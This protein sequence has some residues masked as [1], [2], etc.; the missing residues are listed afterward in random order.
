MSMWRRRPRASAFRFSPGGAH[1][2]MRRS[3]PGLGLPFQ[4]P[5]KGLGRAAGGCAPRGARRATPPGQPPD[6]A[7]DEGRAGCRRGGGSRG[8]RAGGR[9]SGLRGASVDREEL[10]GKCRE[11]L[12]GA[13]DAAG[14]GCLAFRG[15]GGGSGQLRL[16]GGSGCWVKP[17]NGPGSLRRPRGA[18]GQVSRGAARRC[19]TLR[20]FRGA[21]CRGVART[22]PDVARARASPGRPAPPPRAGGRGRRPRA[23]VRRSPKCRA[24]AGGAARAPGVLWNLKK[25]RGGGGNAASPPRRQRAQRTRVGRKGPI[26]GVFRPVAL[27]TLQYKAFLAQSSR[28]REIWFPA[29]RHRLFILIP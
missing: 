9:G 19:R 11:A 27:K 1:A 17:G 20:V 25:V 23:R 7:R 18:A 10:P 8:A 28:T 6:A 29:L 2:P 14:R 3:A 4:A 22:A 16:P 15:A 13:A 21:A 5:G 26:A 12:R 24:G